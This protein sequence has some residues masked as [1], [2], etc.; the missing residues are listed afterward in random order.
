M[1][2][3]S[4]HEFFTPQGKQK[5]TICMNDELFS[6]GYAIKNPKL[7]F[8]KKMF[9]NEVIRALVE[10]YREFTK[11]SLRLLTEKEAHLFCETRKNSTPNE[12]AFSFLGLRDFPR[13]MVFMKD[14]LPLLQNH[15]NDYLYEHAIGNFVVDPWNCPGDMRVFMCYYT[16]NDLSSSLTLDKI[17]EKIYNCH[18][19]IFPYFLKIDSEVPIV[20]GECSICRKEITSL[21]QSNCLSCIQCKNQLHND[22]HLEYFKHTNSIRCMVC[23]TIVPRN[24]LK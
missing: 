6:I 5:C 22:C 7:H 18:L 20:F 13:C 23:K 17:V 14:I 2:C 19:P 15:K 3:L 12:I 21:Q 9:T 4:C 8:S 10:K 1:S 16:T 24:L 11:T